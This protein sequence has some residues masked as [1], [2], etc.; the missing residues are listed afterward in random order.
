[1]SWASASVD[2]DMVT[3]ADWAVLSNEASTVPALT[4]WP[5]LTL[6]DATVP[7]VG[8]LTVLANAGPIVP[9]ET[10]TCVAAPVCTA[11]VR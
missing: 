11:A 6:T 4:G 9:E 10:S 7:E 5:T 3:A 1:M 2:F 8:K